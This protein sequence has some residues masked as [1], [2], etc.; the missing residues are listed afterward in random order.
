MVVQEAVVVVINSVSRAQKMLRNIR[1]LAAVLFAVWVLPVAAA[2]LPDE[3]VDVLGHQYEGGGIRVAGPSILVRKNIGQSVS[4]TANYYV[5]VVSSASID[6]MASA[7]RYSEER[8][9]KSVGV[10]YMHDRTT[11]SL[12]YTTSDEN[13]YHAKS[14]NFGV[15]QTFFG[16]L[17]T[18]NFGFGFGQDLVGKNRKVQGSL[19]G[20]PDP[21]FRFMDKQSRTY[22]LNLSQILTKNLITEL[23]LESATEACV[24]LLE[25]ES[26]LNNPYRDYI[27]LDSTSGFR[28]AAKEKYPLTK[29]SDAASLRAIYHLPF[30]ASI[31]A[32]VRNYSDSWGIKAQNAELRY[33]HDFKKNFLLE[34]KYRVYSQ[35]EA[36]FYSDLFAYK[37]AKNFMARDKELSTFASQTIGLGLTYKLPWIMPG[38]EKSTVNLYWDHMKIDYDNFRDYAHFATPKDAIY[39][40]GEEPLYSLDADVVRLY[41]SFWF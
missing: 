10:D 32:D 28:T 38:T 6:V 15:S 41:L 20:E 12:G 7:S 27:Y 26:C 23:S 4:V 9:Q 14:S 29:N 3:R 13:D 37:D 25:G 36:D 22:S 5:D 33:V 19:I 11:F 8:K 39:K 1:I 35:T 16:D 40:V 21:D 2:V 17:T 18:L 24:N 34:V 30:S 31:R